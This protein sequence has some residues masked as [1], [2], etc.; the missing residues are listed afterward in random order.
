MSQVIFKK[1][2]V[3]FKKDQVIFK[4]SQVIFKTS[5]IIFKIHQVIF[6]KG[7]DIIQT[8]RFLSKV[9]VKIRIS[10][11]ISKI[12]LKYISIK[13]RRFLIHSNLPIT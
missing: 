13:K 2:Q 4:I 1:R 12:I 9:H 6:K 8:S 10:Y 7:G 5:Q 3:I 11:I